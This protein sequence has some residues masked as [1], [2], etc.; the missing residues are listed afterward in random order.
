[1]E[2]L[3]DEGLN[4]TIVWNGR[5]GVEILKEK[6]GPE[7]FDAVLMDLQMPVLDGYEATK[8]IRKE[9]GYKKLPI[10]AMTA[11]ALTGI[12]EKVISVG[13]NDCVTKPI[14]INELFTTLKKWIKPRFGNKQE[15][16]KNKSND[17]NPIIIP[18]MKGFD[19]ATGLKR[20]AGNKGLYKKVLLQLN[21]QL[22]F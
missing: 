17:K 22:A 7:F 16:T 19:T 6:K 11:D 20:M 10:I 13:M 3:E 15:P 18:D 2:I 21:L 1:M 9:L 14:D 8:I 4:M 12:E 5:E